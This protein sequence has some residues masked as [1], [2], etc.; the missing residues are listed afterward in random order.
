MAKN[1]CS[2]LEVLY[3]AARFLPQGLKLRTLT[4]K[5]EI[6]DQILPVIADG[7]NLEAD[8]FPIGFWDYAIYE[9]SL[10]PELFDRFLSEAS[11]EWIIQEGGLQTDIRLK[12]GLVEVYVPVYVTE[13]EDEGVYMNLA[14]HSMAMQVDDPW[15]FLMWQQKYN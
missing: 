3:L 5:M 15:L 7:F 8:Y 6:L 12:K 14:I 13:C 4:S 9:V 10:G 11:G 2:Y 1:I